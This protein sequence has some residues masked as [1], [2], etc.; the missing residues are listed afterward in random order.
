MFADALLDAVFEFVLNGQWYGKAHHHLQRQEQIW[1]DV[2]SSYLDT[3]FL[4]TSFT[5]IRL[6]FWGNTCGSLA[7]SYVSSILNT[8]FMFENSWHRVTKRASKKN[9]RQR[10]IWLGDICFHWNHQFD[11]FGQIIS[12]RMEDGVVFW[13]FVFWVFLNALCFFSLWSWSYWYI[14]LSC[15][16]THFGWDMN[17]IGAVQRQQ[18]ANPYG[19]LA[20]EKYSGPF[21][22]LWTEQ[23]IWPSYTNF[24]KP[25]FPENKAIWRS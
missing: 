13:C 24:T 23:S 11:G 2:R 22:R 6:T 12:L 4:W 5:H 16:K 7:W 3:P 10:S 18:R 1:R 15:N 17:G 20:R 9:R 25:A 21:F 19:L 8:S 14:F